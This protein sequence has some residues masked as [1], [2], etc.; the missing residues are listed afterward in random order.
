MSGKRQNADHRQKVLRK[1]IEGVVRTEH[2]AFASRR[3]FASN[4]RP[5]RVGSTLRF[6]H[7]GMIFDRSA[8]DRCWNKTTMITVSLLG[9][10][11]AKSWREIVEHLNNEVPGQPGEKEQST[12]TEDGEAPR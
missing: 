8:G 4:Q 1:C 10:R 5:A 9:L 2:A 7:E 12:V 3:S 11:I 6:V